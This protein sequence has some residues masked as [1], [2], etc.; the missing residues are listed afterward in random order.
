MAWQMQD[1]KNRLSEVIARA[2]SEGPQEVTVRGKRAAV[3]VAVEEWDRLR[4]ERPDFIDHLL[5]GPEWDDELVGWINDRSKRPSRD[6][7]L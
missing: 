3:I 7:E 1:A 6:I 4:G 2:A 5:S